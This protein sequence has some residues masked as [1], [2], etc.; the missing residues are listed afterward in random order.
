MVRAKVVG[1]GTI[2]EMEDLCD[3][4][5]LVIDEGISTDE[6]VDRLQNKQQSN[7]SIEGM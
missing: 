6:L 7:R 3:E 5:E 1:R 2:N 4:L